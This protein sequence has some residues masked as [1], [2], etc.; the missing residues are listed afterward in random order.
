[1]NM[2]VCGLGLSSP[3]PVRQQAGKPRRPGCPECPPAPS[4]ADKDMLDML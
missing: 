3:G 4:L 1:M 2:E